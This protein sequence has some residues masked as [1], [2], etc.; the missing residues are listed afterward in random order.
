MRPPGGRRQSPASGSHR[1]QRA[2][3]P[4]WARQKW[5]H[6]SEFS[7]QEFSRQEFSRQED[8]KK[9]IFRLC[10]ICTRSRREKQEKS[11]T[12]GQCVGKNVFCK[13]EPQHR[14]HDQSFSYYIWCAKFYLRQAAEVTL[15]HV[16]LSRVTTG[17][18]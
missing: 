1:T 11:R 9:M 6:S 17:P 15:K 7:R 16:R 4:H 10:V 13:L 12:D 8:V 3:F 18:L 2:D 5:I 14:G